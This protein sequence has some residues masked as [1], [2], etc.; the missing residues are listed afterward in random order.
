MGNNTIRRGPCM[1][2]IPLLAAMYILSCSQVDKG[3]GPFEFRDVIAYAGADQRILQYLPIDLDGSGSKSPEGQSLT[4]RW[5]QIAGPKVEIRRAETARAAVT[6][7]ELGEYIFELAVTGS[8]GGI[9]TDQM[10]LSIVPAA[11]V[12]SEYIMADVLPYG[13]GPD[14]LAD[15]LVAYALASDHNTSN[16]DRVQLQITNSIEHEGDQLL[17]YALYLAPVSADYWGIN[18]LSGSSLDWGR[19]LRWDVVPGN[20]ELRALDSIG[21]EYYSRIGLAQ[22]IDS[23]QLS[24]DS[25]IAE[26]P[27]LA[28]ARRL[29]GKLK[30]GFVRNELEYVYAYDL[31]PFIQRATASAAFEVRGVSQSDNAPV[32]ALFDTDTGR[33]RMTHTYSIDKQYCYLFELRG[34]EVHGAIELRHR[35][36]EKDVWVVIDVAPLTPRSLLVNRKISK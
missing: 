23:W 29:V 21:R 28:R 32:V 7:T 4:Y 24:S 11:G 35:A 30:L 31:Q 34:D 19:S 2:C 26:S 13:T 6:P 12:G 3:L 18:L 33:Y 27:D 1:F 36:S 5:N 17:L 9:S 25:A 22:S 16:D 10:T 8:G 14:P 15:L 20:Y